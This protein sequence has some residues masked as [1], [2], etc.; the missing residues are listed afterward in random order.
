MRAYIWHIFRQQVSAFSFMFTPHNLVPCFFFFWFC[1]RRYWGWWRL[2]AAPE[3]LFTYRLHIESGSS[4]ARPVTG[5]ETGAMCAITRSP[6]LFHHY[7]LCGEVLLLSP[8]R[9]SANKTE[10]WRRNTFAYTT[11][12]QNTLI[13]AHAGGLA[14][15]QHDNAVLPLS[16]RPPV[17]C[18]PS[19]NRNRRKQIPRRSEPARVTNTAYT[20]IGVWA[21][22]LFSRVWLQQRTAPHTDISNIATDLSAAPQKPL[23][24][25]VVVCGLLR[26]AHARFAFATN[27]H[28][29]AFHAISHTLIRTTSQTRRG[30][31]GTK[32]KMDDNDELWPEPGK[33]YANLLYSKTTV[34]VA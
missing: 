1:T 2:R 23:V 5:D 20:K 27:C 6:P 33:R 3:T 34:T 18:K 29:A 26:L 9:V 4:F 32:N 24:V 13:S 21:R 11:H 10:R 28:C 30:R 17:R 22:V 15:A 14:C 19:P 16:V 25:V 8:I 31:N 7:I 12:T